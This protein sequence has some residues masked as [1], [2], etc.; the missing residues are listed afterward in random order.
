M[1]GPAILGRDITL[2]LPPQISLATSGLPAGTPAFTGRRRDL[3][4]LLDCLTPNA[5]ATHTQMGTGPAQAVVV[6]AVGGLAGVGKT[7]LAVQAAR[8]A[9][10]RGWFPGGVLFA[11]L[12][13]YDNDRRRD[14][15]QVL[16]GMLGA[17]G[18]SGE[19]IP[20]HAQDRARV[21]RSILAEFA[22]R[23][24]RVL[25]VA[26]NVNT[27]QHAELLLPTDGLNTAIVTSRHTLAMLNARLLDLD[28]LD[29]EGAVAM[30][31]ETL[32]IADPADT[33]IP[34][35]PAG[36]ADLAK[37]CGYLPLAL[38]IA[39]AL[40]AED[41]DHTP[42]AFTRELHQVQPLEGLAYGR[43][44][45]RRA[46]ELSYRT[47]TSR[48][49][50]LFRILT[51]NPGPDT[52]TTTAAVL[53][54]Q[55]PPTVRSALKDLAR[56][57][58]IERG[59]AP[60]RWRMHDLVRQ[61]AT[62]LSEQHAD[63]DHRDQA[64]QRLL[65]VYLH[66]AGAADAHLDPTATDPAARGFATREQALAWLDTELPNLSAAAHTAAE[67]GHLHTAITLPLVL[68]RFLGW[69]RLFNDWITLSALARDTAARTG[70]RTAEGMALN[71]LG[72]ALQQMRQFEE[73]ITTHQDAAAIYRE[74][75]DRHSEGQALNNLGIALQQM[76]RFEE[77][78]TA[79]QDAAAI[80]R[81]TGDRHGEGQAL[82]SLGSALAKVRRFEEAIT[83]HQDAAAILRETGDRHSEGQALNNLGIALAGER[84]FE[85]AIT[86]HQQ[87]LVICRETGDR[88]SEGQALNNLGIALAGERRFEEAIT[89][90]QD[91]AAIYRE[92]GDRHSEGQA[93][94]NLGIVLFEVRRFQE[95]LAAGREAA[96]ILAEVHDEHSEAIARQNV[97]ATLSASTAPKEQ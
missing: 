19:H 77:A 23:D 34:A 55:N 49:Q 86:A 78:I 54:G 28:V 43:D 25:V 87:D 16:E 50:H 22:A 96:E 62:T 60:N 14:P 51:V 12:F 63:T 95:A 39:A 37:V 31:A 59:T 68:A 10:R 52:S 92:T 24:R 47:L 53:T 26:D 32:R 36:S 93:L 4:R 18:V 9:L 76:R 66:T 72:I 29:V 91:A 5:L 85:E 89:A 88:H 84:R 7:E 58:L 2:V 17:L 21:F 8:E 30:L 57:H 3:D 83:T 94:N 82:H 48:Q 65:T 80:L 64:L 67:T 97:K 1:V 11:D 6:T 38:R 13:G 71:N 42:A 74:T 46:F 56:A 35:D 90:H 79:Q 81:E 75:G 15:G 69:R 61:Y 40:L 44:G 27:P 33:R 45:V 70:D 41:P 73:A 20:A